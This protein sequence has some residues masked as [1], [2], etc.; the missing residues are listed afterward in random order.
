MELRQ[1]KNCQKQKFT[2]VEKIEILSEIKVE[3]SCGLDT[4]EAQTKPLNIDIALS[5]VT[6]MNEQQSQAVTRTME[7][8][9]QSS[10]THSIIHKGLEG[11]KLSLHD[12]KTATDAR[13]IMKDKKIDCKIC[14]KTLASYGYLKQHIEAVHKK[15]KPHQCTICAKRFSQNT[16]LKVHVNSVHNTVTPL[17]CKI[18]PKK[19]ATNSGLRKHINRIHNKLKEACVKKLMDSSQYF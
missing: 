1:S 11:Y 13:S 7:E 6:A 5:G 17:E 15:M 19:F 12:G 8:D 10:E 14:S 3:N 2:D 16:H 9:I 18:C 4:E